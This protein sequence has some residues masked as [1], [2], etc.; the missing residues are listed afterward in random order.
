MLSLAL[1]RF[2]AMGA[3]VW[4]SSLPMYHLTKKTI[5]IEHQ[6]AENWRKL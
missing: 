5:E 2:M 1:Y 3:Q 4:R 6:I